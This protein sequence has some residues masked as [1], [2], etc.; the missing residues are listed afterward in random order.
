MTQKTAGWIIYVQDRKNQ[1][2]S[3]KIRF[4]NQTIHW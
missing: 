1:T 2:D 3:G 4:E